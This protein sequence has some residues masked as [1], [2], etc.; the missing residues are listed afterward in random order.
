MKFFVVYN[1]STQIDE[2][3]IQSIVPSIHTRLKMY[4]V[5]KAQLIR[6]NEFEEGEW[7]RTE[8]LPAHLPEP[9]GVW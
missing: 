4:E 3:M 5:Y 8:V 1:N 2:L 6:H 7:R 9:C